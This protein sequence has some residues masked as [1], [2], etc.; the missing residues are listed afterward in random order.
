MPALDENK[1]LIKEISFTVVS[2]VAGDES[3][4]FG[5]MFEEYYNKPLN[6][7]SKSDDMLGFGVEGILDISTP[8]VIGMVTSVTG[9]LFSEIVKTFRE[10]S[11]EVIKD[12]VK[13][14]FNKKT[15]VKKSELP[16]LT[17]EQFAIIKKLAKDEAVRFGAS[18]D[19]AEKMSSSLIGTMN[20]PHT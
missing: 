8:V 14:L 1:E 10:Q 20:L 16:E 7:S 5:E 12:K 9:F 15:E 11:A 2:D 4:M 18:E 3:E 19:M 17:S 6:S 13:K